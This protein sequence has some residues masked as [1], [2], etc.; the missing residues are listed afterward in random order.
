MQDGLRILGGGYFKNQSA[1]GRRLADINAQLSEENELIRAENALKRQRAQIEE[2]SR[3]MDE[4]IALVP[5][6]VASNQ[7]ASGKR[8][9]SKSETSL[10]AGRISQAPGQSGADLR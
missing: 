5:T 1:S 9:R 3:L 7:S 10:S 8:K 6:P 2:K 4:M